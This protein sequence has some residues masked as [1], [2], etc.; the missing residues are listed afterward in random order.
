MRWGQNASNSQVQSTVAG[1]QDPVGHRAAYQRC[2]RKLQVAKR[3]SADAAYR[4]SSLL[5]LFA[6][7]ETDSGSICSQKILTKYQKLTDANMIIKYIYIDSFNVSNNG[8][9]IEKSNTF[10]SLFNTCIL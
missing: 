3:G 4:R 1:L 8:N 6:I 2:T 5:L 9:S 7:V 10:R